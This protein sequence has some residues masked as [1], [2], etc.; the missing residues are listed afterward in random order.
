MKM[1]TVGGRIKA[2]S[3]G[4]NHL[5]ARSDAVELDKH[6]KQLRKRPIRNLLEA[7]FP[8]DYGR[9]RQ[10]MDG[11]G[12]YRPVLKT[13]QGMAGNF[14]PFYIDEKICISDFSVRRIISENGV[15]IPEPHHNHEKAVVD[16]VRKAFYSFELEEVAS[17]IQSVDSKRQAE[18]GR[19]LFMFIR[20]AIT[21]S[22]IVFGAD[23]IS[24]VTEAV[25][26][27]LAKISIRAR[28]LEKQHGGTVQDDRVIYCQPDVYI[29]ADGSVAVEKINCPDVGFFISEVEDSLSPIF[30][31][32]KKIVYELQKQFFDAIPDIFKKGK[33]FLLTRDE[34]IENKED[35]LEIKEI[36][37]LLK[38]LNALG[39]DLVVYPVSRVDEIPLGSKVILLNINYES[40]AAK[41]ILDRHCRE[42]IACYPN[43][44]FQIACRDITGLREIVIPEKHLKAFIQLISSFPKNDDAIGNIRKQIENLLC[45]YQIDSDILHV[46]VAN[47]V[48]PVFSRSLHSWRQL[49][50]RIKRHDL[51]EEVKIKIIPASPENL[52]ITSDTGPRLHSFRFMFVR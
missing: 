34:V 13:D 42:E 22:K 41:K 26:N 28:E 23:I 32:I 51:N 29:L 8:A 31:S 7:F 6:L 39:I 48:V 38:G 49:A 40:I 45:K 12:F 44:F 37:S 9:L 46:S 19:E 10:M 17:L 11:V 30:G 33:A 25:N 16:S 20:P 2:A 14:L 47:E 36:E 50:R 15:V 52:M 4:L 21:D 43:P 27:V 5:Y 35:V 3:V 18:K 24:A 1:V